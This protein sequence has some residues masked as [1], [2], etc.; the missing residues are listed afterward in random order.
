ML[1]NLQDWLTNQV[2]QPARDEPHALLSV[3]ISRVKVTEL[4]LEPIRRRPCETGKFSGRSNLY[5]CF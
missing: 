4:P 1:Q 5:P 3:D 2:M